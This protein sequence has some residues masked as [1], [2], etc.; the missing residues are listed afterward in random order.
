MNRLRQQSLQAER[1]TLQALLAAAEDDD[2]LGRFSLQDRLDEVE[3]ELRQL[4]QHPDAEASVAIMFG[5]RPVTGSRAIDAEFATDVLRHFTDLVS[6]QIAA[7]EEGGL[8]ARGPIPNRHLNRLA[9]ADVVRGSFGFVLEEQRENLPLADTPTKMAVEEIARIVA[10]SASPNDEAFE[11]IVET[12]DD[13]R[14]VSLRDLFRKLDDSGATIRL[15]ER[16]RDDSLDAQAI[17]RARER[18]DATEIEDRQS[19]Q[20][21]GRLLGL[22]PIGRRFDMR[23]SDTGALIRGTVAARYATEYLTLIE[24]PGDNPVG[25]DWRVKMRIREIRERNKP[26]RMT[27]TLLGLLEELPE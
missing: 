4:E 3:E 8:G 9:I 20:L 18:I 14:L 15:V 24:R 10:T 5:G 13:R 2:P 27:Y 7:D 21:R 17:H 23:L 26:P 16:D 25:K 22:T 1:T 6:K 19:E 12:L 11:A